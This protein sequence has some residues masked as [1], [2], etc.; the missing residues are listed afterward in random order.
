MFPHSSGQHKLVTTVFNSTSTL[1]FLESNSPRFSLKNFPP[2]LARRSPLTLYPN[3]SVHPLPLDS[4]S[5][6]SSSA[7]PTRSPAPSDTRSPASV[8]SLLSQQTNPPFPLR[9]TKCHPTLM[10]NSCPLI[11]KIL[12]PHKIHVHPK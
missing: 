1:F 10:T 11:P 8:D 7:P 5:Q 2:P 3:D 9:L 6:N 4:M 12:H